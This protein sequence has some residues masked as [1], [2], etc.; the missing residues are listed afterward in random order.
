MLS[1]ARAAKLT[2]AVFVISLQACS[3][4]EEELWGLGSL[5]FS[6]FVIIVLLQ[7]FI[8][9]FQEYEIVQG[10]VDFF[11]VLVLK[12]YLYLFFLSLVLASLGLF[13]LVNNSEH[14]SKN[15]LFFIGVI[16][17]YL[18]INLK[19]WAVEKDK[20][21]KR[22]YVRTVGLSLTFIFFMVYLMMGAP[23]LSL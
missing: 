16:L 8:P 4:N 6:V 5:V 10:W 11:Q 7:T 2:F 12:G 14:S 20:Y 18:S 15:L 21:R 1:N 22:N 9:I 13:N 19:K 3:P 17:F 23:N